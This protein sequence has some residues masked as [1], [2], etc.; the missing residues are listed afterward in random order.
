MVKYLRGYAANAGE[1]GGGR[2]IYGSVKLIR[3]ICIGRSRHKCFQ[4]IVET[5]ED[6][7]GLDPFE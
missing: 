5:G 6:I 1:G 4:T 3:D 7:L 2:V